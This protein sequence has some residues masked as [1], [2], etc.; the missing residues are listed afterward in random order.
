MVSLKGIEVVNKLSLSKALYLNVGVEGK[1][2]EMELDTGASITVMS[3]KEFTNTFQNVKL[4][5]CNYN[6]K[7]VSGT[8]LDVV[9][10]AN[11]T[12]SFLDRSTG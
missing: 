5:S 4:S 11:V 12:V 6:V 8:K 7:T 9:G 2:I 3:K 10:Q 1:S